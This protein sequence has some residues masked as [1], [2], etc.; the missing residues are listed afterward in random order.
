MHKQKR[1]AEEKNRLPLGLGVA[2][3]DAQF[4]QY[5]LPLPLR[6]RLSEV[7]SFGPSGAATYRLEHVYQGRVGGLH[8]RWRKN[9]QPAIANRQVEQEALL[10]PGQKRGF[11]DCERIRIMK[12]AAWLLRRRSAGMEHRRSICRFQRND[13][14]RKS[15]RLNSSHTVISYAVFC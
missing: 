11:I 2:Q 1:C 5:Q 15:T 3:G 10:E 7:I 6:S 9:R 12:V 8:G 14:D 4:V 13:G